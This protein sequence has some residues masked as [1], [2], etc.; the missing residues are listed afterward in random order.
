ML[1]NVISVVFTFGII[2]FLH[3]LG[4]FLIARKL[5]V[6]VE[7]FAF[8]FG[9]ELVGKTVNGTRYCICAIPLGGLVKLAGE[10][11]EDT[12]GAPD[13][14]FSQVW[15]K[16]IYIVLSGPVMNYLLA[17][18]FFFIAVFFWGIGIPSNKPIIGEV[19]KG[20][21]ADNAGLKPGDEIVSIDDKKVTFWEDAAKIIHK[22]AEK[23]L[24]LKIKR[25]DKFFTLKLTPKLD[26]NLNVG[27]IG[28]TPEVKMQK[29]NV[30]KSFWISI[31][32]TVGLNVVLI[33]YIVDRIIKLEKP[34]VAGPIGIAQ[35]VTQTAQKG[36]SSLIILIGRI[37]VTVGLLNLFPIPV[38]DGGHIMFYLVEGLI[39]RR[40]L[41]KKVIEI[42]NA[43]GITVISIIVIFAF[44]SDFERLGIVR[45]IQRLL[46]L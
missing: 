17:L 3:E 24:G 26:K 18:I 13:E 39:I 43:V 41:K 1:V 36:L 35:I 42:A 23:E 45:I 25:K 28:I 4:H 27:L 34:E 30:F 2:I 44:Y 38:F 12:T 19:V 31:Q 46:G 9:P 14:F 8:G 29:V 11:P 16:R 33:S 5:K 7:K 22:S 20:M 6:R 10:L 40:P 37:S 15:Y 21:P 32:H